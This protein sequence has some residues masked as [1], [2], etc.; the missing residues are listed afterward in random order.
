M[1]RSSPGR[2]AIALFAL[3]ALL[4][5]ADAAMPEGDRASPKAG[6]ATAVRVAATSSQSSSPA[7]TVPRPSGSDM[8][9]WTVDLGTPRATTAQIEVSPPG[10][11]QTS[12]YLAPGAF[13][14]DWT[15]Y[16]ALVFEKKSW[17]GSYYGPDSYAAYGDVVVQSG[18]AS[19]RFDIPQDHSGE[20]RS[21]RVPLDGPGWTL[22][23]AGSLAAVLSNVTGLK[24][25]AEYGAGTDYSALRSVK[26]L[27]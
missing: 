4:G 24:I 10:E 18:A 20:W 25:R 26:L 15:G 3:Q 13:G 11:G 9:A 12:Y 21:Y 6:P 22:S 2:V 14:G 19:A 23:G 7:A 8:S 17:G 27:P 1:R 16:G 5:T